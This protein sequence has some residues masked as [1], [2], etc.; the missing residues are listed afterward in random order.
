MPVIPD[1][2][3]K[4]LVIPVRDQAGAGDFIHDLLM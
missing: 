3:Q 2:D 1:T 4:Q